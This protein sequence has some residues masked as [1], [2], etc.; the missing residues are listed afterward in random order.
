[1]VSFNGNKFSINH[2]N[3]ALTTPNSLG[4]LPIFEEYDHF[5][6]FLENWEENYKNFQLNPKKIP[7]KLISKE[8]KNLF[9]KF[10]FVPEIIDLNNKSQVELNEIIIK[11]EKMRKIVRGWVGRLK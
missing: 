11:Q 5:N 2:A 3:V 1:A 4:V 6:K 10:R 7:N 8:S 9:I